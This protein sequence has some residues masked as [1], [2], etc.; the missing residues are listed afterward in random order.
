MEEQTFEQAADKMINWWLERISESTINL[1]GRNSKPDEE[2][3]V[4]FKQEFKRQL[5]LID[6][7]KNYRRSREWSTDSRSR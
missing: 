7:G 1:P 4:L 6:K 3:I 2:K 5:L